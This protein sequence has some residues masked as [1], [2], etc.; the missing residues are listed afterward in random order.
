M[1]KLLQWIAGLFA[2]HEPVLSEATLRDTAAIGRIHA[3]SFHRGWSDDEIE[4][5]LLDRNVL[6]HRAT[7]GRALVGFV[8]SRRAADEAEI[9]SIAVS[10]RHGRRGL[11]RALLRLHL[12]R[13]SA[14]GVKNVFLEVDESNEPANRLYHRAGFREAGRRKGYYPRTEH[15]TGDALILRREIA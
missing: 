8:M 10:G 3:K 1:K 5:L 14:L 15:A 9:L 6:A 11:G 2:G 12:G 7:I 4:R 13:L